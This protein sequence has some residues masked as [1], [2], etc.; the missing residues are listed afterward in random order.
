MADIGIAG[1]SSGY[2]CRSGLPYQGKTRGYIPDIYLEILALMSA[3]QVSIKKFRMFI[4]GLASALFAD[5][6][7]NQQFVAIITGVGR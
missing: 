6:W 2:R 7:T 3:N 5:P 1:E 4:V